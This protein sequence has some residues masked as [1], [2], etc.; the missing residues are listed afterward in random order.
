MS[1]CFIITN[2]PNHVLCSCGKWV[3]KKT[4]QKHRSGIICTRF[5]N[6][7]IKKYRFI[8]IP[9]TDLLNILKQLA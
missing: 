1:K 4:L 6:P 7:H 2:R 3:R 8:K 9:K 5:H